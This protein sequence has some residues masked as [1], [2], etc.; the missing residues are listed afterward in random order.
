MNFI[1]F[2]FTYTFILDMNMSKAVT[3]INPIINIDQVFVE[4]YI[5]VMYSNLKQVAVSH[6][7]SLR[8]KLLPEI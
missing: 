1:K 7:L 4:I 2:N 8:M 6:K 3:W 5:A